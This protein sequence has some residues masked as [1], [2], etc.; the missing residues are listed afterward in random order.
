MQ[1]DSYF[2]QFP[3]KV[4]ISSTKETEPMIINNTVY[5]HYPKIREKDIG[6]DTS[7][8]FIDTM[9]VCNGYLSAMGADYDGENCLTGNTA[10]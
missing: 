10:Y 1:R 2:N 4:N 9:N 7:N 8:L 3:T 5:R 6:K